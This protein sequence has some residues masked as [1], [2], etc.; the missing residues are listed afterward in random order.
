MLSA[1][2]RN[3]AGRP[4]LRNKNVQWGRIDVDDL[5]HMDFSDEEFERFR[6]HEGDLLVCEG[7]EVGRAAIW[8]APIAECGYQKALHRVRP[9]GGV[10]PEFLLYLMR[11]Y[12][13]TRLFE[14][15]VT[16][17]TIDHLPQEDL[18][19]LP[20]PLP[21]LAEQRRIVAAI[22][23]QLSR[24]DAAEASVTSAS[25]RLTTFADAALR[26][27]GAHSHRL[28][29]VALDLRYGT[30]AKCTYEGTGPAVLRIPN[31]RNQR[32]DLTDLKCAVDPMV[33]VP[34]VEMG[35]LL[36]V[37]TNGSRDLIGRVGVVGEGASGV[38][39]ASYLI[40]AR[41]DC[42]TADSAFVALALSTRSA[43]A[44]IER[45]AATTAGQ[46]NLSAKAI[47]D[48]SIPL[49]HLEEQRRLRTEIEERLVAVERL[50]FAFDEALRR[51]STLRRS[52]LATAFRGELVPQDPDDEPASVLLERIA[53]ERAATPKTTRKRRK[54]AAA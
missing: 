16:G 37:R 6:L 34:T 17:S 11:Y 22:E 9:F 5:L 31:I 24:L 29:D 32:I 23:E 4:Y 1:K 19:Q 14:R 15:Y 35:D 25:V 27:V 18:R 8:R 47:A 41:L 21:P 38:G 52:I 40:R 43:R 13:D 28:R 3:G 2:A 12:A 45:R 48:L 53:A 49:P 7:G 46:Y 51:G 44:E 50:R 33:D 26:T 30:S 54:V 20:V 10:A 39:F 42:H 36:F